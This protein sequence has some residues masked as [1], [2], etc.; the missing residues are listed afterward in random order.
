MIAAATSNPA[1]LLLKW[2]MG[3]VGGP[4]TARGTDLRGAPKGVNGKIKHFRKLLQLVL[5]FACGK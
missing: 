2:L 4:W 1:W 3:H 5:V